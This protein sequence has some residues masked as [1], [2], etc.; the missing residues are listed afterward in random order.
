VGVPTRLVRFHEEYHGTGSK[1]SNFMRTQLYL[2]SWFGEH[3]REA[4]ED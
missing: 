2:L 3:T 4:A 1:P